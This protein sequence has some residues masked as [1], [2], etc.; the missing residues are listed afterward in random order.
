M[1]PYRTPVVKVLSE[2]GSRMSGLSEEEAKE[3]LE[4]Y[5]KNEITREKPVSPFKIFISQFKDL[6]IWILIFATVVAG[7]TGEY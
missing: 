1:E 6:L 5:G 3:R 2:L 7:V 4:K